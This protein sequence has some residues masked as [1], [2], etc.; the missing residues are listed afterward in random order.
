M[1]KSDHG[2]AEVSAFLAERYA[3]VSDVAPIGSGEWSQAFSFR[4]ADGDRV[5]RFGLHRDDYEKDRHAMRFAGPDLPVP[6]ILEVGEAFGGAFA[7]SERAFGHGFDGGSEARYR[8]VLPAVFAV[9]VALARADISGSTGYGMWNPAGRAP[10]AS[11]RDMLL[12]SERGFESERIRGWRE[13]LERV[14]EAVRNFDE[15]RRALARLVDEACEQRHL[16]HADLMG[17]NLLL[18][19]DRVVAVLDWGNSMYGDFLYDLARMTFFAPWFDDLDRFE[20]RGLARD[21]YRTRG[22][23]VP[24]FNERLRCCEVHLGIDAQVYNAF[25]GRYDELER[26]GRRTLELAQNDVG[27]GPLCAED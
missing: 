8:E 27:S 15:S 25:T 7:V 3:A 16:I 26:S 18:D 11:W 24:H 2:I 21:A 13:R 17:D 5:A 19:G 1:R 22:L 20:L 14:P 6:M 12:D 23:D 9:H 4:C 10:Y